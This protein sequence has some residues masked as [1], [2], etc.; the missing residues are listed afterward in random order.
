V[1]IALPT[2]P[3]TIQ[4]SI[5]W[6]NLA[7]GLSAM[8]RRVA[9][10]RI[11]R[12]R[13]IV[14]AEMSLRHA[15]TSASDG[16]AGR[17]ADRPSCLLAARARLQLSLDSRAPWT[18]LALAIDCR[19]DRSLPA[20]FTIC[21]RHCFAGVRAKGPGV[22]GLFRYYLGWVCWDWFALDSGGTLVKPDP[23]PVLG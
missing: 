5:P 7:A 15:P 21:L 6:D 10:G 23:P 8:P 19:N 4:A 11:A 20:K 14:S 13:K 22:R 1:G 3:M 2:L 18:C 17:L 9:A 16:I 12:K